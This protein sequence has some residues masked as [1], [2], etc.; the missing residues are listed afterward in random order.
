MFA[1]G[2]TVERYHEHRRRLQEKLVV[3]INGEKY[4]LF[5]LWRRM[6][7]SYS[8]VDGFASEYHR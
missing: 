5:T 8:N 2:K 3:Q 7:V 6:I 4:S 1:V